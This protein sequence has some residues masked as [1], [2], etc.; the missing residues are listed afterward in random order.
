M[1][2]K[3]IEILIAEDDA[4]HAA[5]VKRNMIRCGITNTI[6]H[7]TDGQQVLDF[8]F[9]QGAGAMEA[10]KRYLL[11]LD[12]RMPKVDGVDVLRRIKADAALKSTP[13]IMMTTMD[14]P[15]EV[16]KCYELGCEKYFSKPVDFVELVEDMKKIF[17]SL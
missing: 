4:G 6:K 1:T 17:V 5:L 15:R 9:G 13:V 14:D 11:L 8:M 3:E 16:S 10:D 7:F 12:I 2:D